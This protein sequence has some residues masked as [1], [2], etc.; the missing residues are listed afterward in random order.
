MSGYKK[1]KTDG[2][3]T[4]LNLITKKIREMKKKRIKELLVRDRRHPLAVSV[5]LQSIYWLGGSQLGI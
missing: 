4:R 2:R 3:E 5:F 1:I